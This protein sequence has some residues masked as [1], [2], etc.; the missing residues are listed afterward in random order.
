M[1]LKIHDKPGL[2]AALMSAVALLLWAVFDAPGGPRWIALPFALL[3][4][5]LALLCVLGGLVRHMMLQWNVGK[6]GAVLLVPSAAVLGLLVILTLPSAPSAAGIAAPTFSQV[7][8][9]VG[10]RCLPCHAIHPSD[11]TFPAAPNGVVFEDPAVLQ[12]FATK[13]KERVFVTKT[14]PLV[15]RTQITEEERAQ[16]AAWVDSGAPIHD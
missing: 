16:L 6:T 11:P 7:Q 3:Y 10:Q 12:K 13:I 9:I 8:A 14:M 2:A 1:K 4:S 5:L 15:N